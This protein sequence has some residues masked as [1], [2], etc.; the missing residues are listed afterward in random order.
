MQCVKYEAPGMNR[1]GDTVYFA[2]LSLTSLSEVPSKDLTLQM[3]QVWRSG[4]TLPGS[5][6]LVTALPQEERTGQVLRQQN[7]VGMAGN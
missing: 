1:G 4:Y 6:K 5:T 2:L 3:G 7:A